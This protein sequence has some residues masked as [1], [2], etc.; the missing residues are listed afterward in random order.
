MRNILLCLIIL[1]A[2]VASFAQT[3][4]RSWSSDVRFSDG[5]TFASD[6][7]IN[8]KNLRLSA[9]NVNIYK[10]VFKGKL[11]DIGKS[12]L[13]ISKNS[14]SAIARKN[15]LLARKIKQQIN[16]YY[17]FEQNGKDITVF[18]INSV[19]NQDKLYECVQNRNCQLECEATII[20]LNIN[21]KTENLVLITSLK[22]LKD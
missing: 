2:S 21:D 12:P 3:D 17:S 4:K 6:S 1:L 7:V 9:G 10:K 8:E 11:L 5:T 16:G 14:L 15:N 13:Q 20:Q 22:I 19:K 18:G